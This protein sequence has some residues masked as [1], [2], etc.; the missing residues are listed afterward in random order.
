MEKLIMTT[1]E[2]S[3]SEFLRHAIQTG[4][5]LMWFLGAGASRSSGLATAS[6]ITWDLKKQ[7]YCL[8]QN[9]D[10]KSHDVSNKAVRTRIQSYLDSRGFPPLWD[11]REYSFYFELT[12]GK[13]YAA[14]Q[15]YLQEALSSEKI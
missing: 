14:Q 15:K 8:Q 12:F 2:L 9:Q 10:V 11:A 7:Y 1:S 4:P 6:D 3:E 13:D 5:H